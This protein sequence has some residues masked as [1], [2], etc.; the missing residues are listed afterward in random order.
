MLRGLNDPAAWLFQ[1]VRRYTDSL[2]VAG[3]QLVGPQLVAELDQA[4][5]YIPGLTNQ[6]AWPTL[7]AHLL[8]LAAETGEYP[9]CHL[10]TAARGRDLRTAGDMA[11]VL[12]WRLAELAPVDL[13]PLPWLPGIPETLRCRPVWGPYLTKRSC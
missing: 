13:G 1:A 9:L 2:L 4:D 12:Y 10:L 3:E 5:H 8:T 7:R 6:P 11:A